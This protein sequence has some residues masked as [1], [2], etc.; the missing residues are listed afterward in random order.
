TGVFVG[1]S[2]SAL[3]WKP[4]PGVKKTTPRGELALKKLAGR[5]FGAAKASGT[6]SQLISRRPS[7]NEPPTPLLVPRKARK[8]STVAW[9]SSGIAPVAS[10]NS[11]AAAERASIGSDSTKTAKRMK[12]F[13]NRSLPSF[14]FI[15]CLHGSQFGTSTDAFPLIWIMHASAGP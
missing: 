11:A 5:L 9:I 1:L 12:R 8:A 14:L 7:G 15:G 6:A 4:V 10:K 13:I 2:L 3:T